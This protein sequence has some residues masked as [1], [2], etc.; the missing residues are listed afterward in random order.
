METVCEFNECCGCNACIEICPQK[1]IEI[2]TINMCTNAI[3][4][5]K[6]CI[7][8]DMCTNVC[9]VFNPN[10]IK[11]MD[12]KECYEGY[13]L[14]EKVR[15][16]SSSGGFATRIGLNFIEQHGY[17]AGVVQEEGRYIYKLTNKRTELI[18]F[19]GSKYIKSDL[20]RIMNEVK[21]KLQN[22]IKVLFI[23]L[24]CHIAG[25]KLFLGNE[26]EYLYTID[27]VCHGT[28]DISILTRYLME[29]G[30]DPKSISSFRNKN[31]FQL[32]K[33][34]VSINR[35]GVKDEYTL[36]F[37]NGLFYTNNCYS[38]KYARKERIADLTIGDSWGSKAPTIEKKRGLSLILVQTNKGKDLLKMIEKEFILADADIENARKNNRQ[39][40]EP[41]S[42]HR[43]RRKFEKYIN[44]KTIKRA[45]IKC[46]RYDCFKQNIKNI[47]IA[48]KI[49]KR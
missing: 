32:Y 23:G 9:Q 44:K 14:D 13:D 12:T 22:H 45:I 47:L 8:C 15:L 29:Q 20:N 34:E 39:L 42:I 16:R 25:L 38:C 33:N 1:C 36:G 19:S 31:N 28:P 49:L 5:T 21:N 7:N 40:V 4:D 41:S 35:I 2:E 18:S 37:L 10:R 3:I 17:V 24:P 43:N 48:S 46:L 27:L 26:N 11:Y 30:I 6:K